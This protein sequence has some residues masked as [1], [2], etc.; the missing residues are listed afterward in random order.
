[1]TSQPKRPINFLIGNHAPFVVPEDIFEYVL[2]GVRQAGAPIHYSIDD[3][4]GDAINILMEGSS[5]ESA[6]SF[7]NL[8]GKYP[9]SKLYVIATEILTPGGFNSANVQL[10]PRS[11]Q[12]ANAK[13]AQLNAQSDHYADAGYWQG[14]TQAFLELVRQADG[15][16]FLAESLIDGYRHLGLKWHYLPLVCL[17]DYPVLQRASEPQRDIDVFFSGT[18]TAYRHEVLEF[19]RQEGFTVVAQPPQCPD[20]VR[21]HFLGRSKLAVGLRLDQNT[22]FTSKQRAH[23]YL[24]NRVPHLFETTPD[25]TDL[26]EFVQFA[27]PGG[28]FLDHCYEM[29]NGIQ[30][31]PHHVFDDFRRCEK[32]DPAIVFRNFL[33]FLKQ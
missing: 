20:Y 11:D 1:M 15:L 31:F 12:H 8:R 2:H 10:N 33:A 23:Y 6:K 16:V 24:V 4:R 7:A 25:H 5:L 14:R 26:H 21:R 29:V 28:A 32:L 17:P 3:Y 19:L 30:V 18:L 13:R 27:E 9:N 22:R